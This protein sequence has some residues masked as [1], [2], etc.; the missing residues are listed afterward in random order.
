[1]K[2][3]PIDELVYEQMFPKPRSNDPQNFQGLLQRFIIPE[4]RHETH[5]FFGHLDTQEAK[6][7]GLDYT[8][9]T[10]RIRLSRWPWHRRLFRA[11]DALR[12]T[13]SEIHGLTKWEG[14]KW[15]KD[16]YE[17]EQ[18]ITIRDTTM[19]E[20]PDWIETSSV[21]SGVTVSPSQPTLRSATPRYAELISTSQ[22][23]D[24]GNL[25]VE[26]EMMDEDED[27]D[28]SDG[29]LLD[30]VGVAL[31]E[32]LRTQAAR[33]DAGETAVIMDEQWEQWFK[34]ALESGNLTDMSEQMTE[35]ILRHGWNSTTFPTSTIPS[36][37]LESAR[38]GQWS[39]IPEALH[40]F[41]RQSMHQDGSSRGQ[42]HL[43]NTPSSVSGSTPP[44]NTLRRQFR[45]ENGRPRL[46]WPRRTYSDLRLPGTQSLANR[47]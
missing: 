29:E 24:S 14:T 38:S 23:D 42:S 35:Q 17:K 31:N 30:S 45:D 46:P 3:R 25:A 2:G 27:E 4:V 32:R 34:T 22:D 19:D 9:P 39:E 36:T 5:A 26:D 1:M 13:P 18:G 10:H 20:L 37:M 44:P 47:D 40:P 33:R 43:R 28:D 16:K 11:F 12:L 8:H 6:Y 7:P 21:S 15:A 41:L